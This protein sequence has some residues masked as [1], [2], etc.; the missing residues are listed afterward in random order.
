MNEKPTVLR[1]IEGGK[2]DEQ[3]EPKLAGSGPKGPDWLR[4][5]E[6]GQK[7]IAYPKQL[8]N[9]V[10][11]S[12]FGVAY[13]MDEAVLLACDEPN[14]LGN[15]MVLKWCNSKNFSQMYKLVAIL[16]EYNPDTE[17]GNNEQRNLPRP[18][19]S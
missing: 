13:K 14:N 8:A 18:A 7:F 10:F 4:D 5:I 1:L 16:P 3:I 12:Q 6:Y 19:D 9:P 11:Y 15:A 2:S 17:A